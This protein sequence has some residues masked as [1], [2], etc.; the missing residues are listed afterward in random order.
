MPLSEC[1]TLS[2]AEPMLFIDNSKPKIGKLNAF[3]DERMGADDKL[4]LTASDG[5]Q[6]VVALLCFL[7]SSKPHH[8][9][10]KWFEPLGNFFVML[11]GENFSGRH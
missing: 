4:S 11:L 1:Q 6:T 5:P 3:L 2:H 8:V 10:A 9:Y 7:F